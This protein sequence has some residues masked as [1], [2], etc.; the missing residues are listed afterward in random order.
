[1][2]PPGGSKEP[3][4]FRS[5]NTYARSGDPSITLT[6]VV[7]NGAAIAFEVSEQGNRRTLKKVK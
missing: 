4:L 6:F 7:E 5:G 3:L 1:M 2:T